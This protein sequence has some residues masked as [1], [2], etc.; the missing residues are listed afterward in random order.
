MRM[1]HLRPYSPL[2]PS[3][4][5]F[6][7]SLLCSAVFFPRGA[8]PQRRVG[9]RKDHEGAAARRFGGEAIR[10]VWGR[11]AGLAAPAVCAYLDRG[12]SPLS[13]VV[14]GFPGIAFVLARS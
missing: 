11:L 14:R 13:E 10:M 12:S 2:P 8:G 1:N 9:A 4:P 3:L 6:V 7:F 5:T